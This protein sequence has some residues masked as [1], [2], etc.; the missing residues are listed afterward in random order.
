MFTPPTRLQSTVASR[1]RRRCVLGMSERARIR[2]RCRVG[3]RFG[4]TICRYYHGKAAGIGTWGE[5]RANFPLPS[6]KGTKPLGEMTFYDWRCGKFSLAATCYPSAEQMHEPRTT[7]DA[8][9][10][11]MKY[12]GTLWYRPPGGGNKTKQNCGKNNI[13]LPQRCHTTR[14]IIVTEVN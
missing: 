4:N 10:L 1:R 3:P 8:P 9:K 2:S 6:R 5:T 14:Q 12:P 7:P 11:Q 13:Y